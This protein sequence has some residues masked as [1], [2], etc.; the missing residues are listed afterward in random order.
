MRILIC[1]DGTLVGKTAVSFGALLARAAQADVTLLGIALVPEAVARLRQE[2]TLVQSLL[3]TPAEE[4]VRQSRMA[5]AILGEADSGAYDLIVVGSRGRRGLERL[6][7]GSVA[8]QLARYA[9]IPVLIVKG[10]ARPAV[11]RVLACTSGDVRGERVARWGGQLARWLNAEITVLHVMSQIALS[12]RAK[13]DEL[14]GSAEEALAQRTREGLH[15]AREMELLRGQK[16]TTPLGVR[17]KLRHGLV[18]EEIVA[19]TEEGDYDLVVI[20]GHAA[21]ESPKDWDKLGFLLEDV[22]DQ[23]VSAMQRPVLVVK[24]N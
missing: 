2:L 19:E 23:I 14:M 20:G 11:R 5:Q 4:K 3:P 1:T 18:V 9:R 12:P 24:G 13:F 22:A 7:F 17:P 21:P 10:E 15:L 16:G 6:A 8:A